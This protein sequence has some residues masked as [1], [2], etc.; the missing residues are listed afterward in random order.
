[1]VFIPSRAQLQ[2]QALSSRATD[3]SDDSNGSDWSTMQITTPII[4]GVALIII[5]A[6]Y[7]MW[8]RWSHHFKPHFHRVRDASISKFS[9]IFMPQYRRRVQHTSM[10]VTLDESM[11]T[12]RYTRRYHSYVRS[13]S[14]DSQTPLRNSVEFSFPPPNGY[15]SDPSNG[16]AP[17]GSRRPERRLWR[18]WRLFGVG[19]REVKPKVP[20]HRWVVE[21]PDES[22]TVGHGDGSFNNQ[23]VEARQR[24]ASGLAPVHEQTSDDEG[25]SSR[26]I[27]GGVIQIGDPDFSTAHSATPMSPTDH[28]GFAIPAPPGSVPTSAR[29]AAP[30][31]YSAVEGPYSTSNLQAMTTAP[32]TYI[33]QSSSTPGPTHSNSPAPPMY[34][35]VSNSRNSTESF[36]YPVNPDLTALYPWSVR[37]VGRTLPR[38]YQHERQMS[39][40]SMLANSSPMVPQSM[41]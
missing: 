9:K 19:P 10:P 2:H 3:G 35:S 12:P 21:G 31:Y 29:T 30:E 34:S 7:V 32:T 38:M 5:F 24:W 39:T 16:P 23:S 40:E 37:A 11:V 14:T 15:H 1:M 25:D 6:V 28:Q 27:Y 8:D 13:D 20:S 26:G 41:Y 4:V 33:Q 22:S 18:W 36:A 17:G